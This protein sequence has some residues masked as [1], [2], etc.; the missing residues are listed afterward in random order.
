[1]KQTIT[2]EVPE[3]KVAVIEGNKIIFKDKNDEYPKTWE[4]YLK[5]IGKDNPKT[6]PIKTESLSSFGI[7]K[8]IMTLDLTGKDCVA[9]EAFC[10]LWYLRDY[11]RN[12]SH[13]IGAENTCYIRVTN[14]HEDECTLTREITTGVA[15]DNRSAFLSFPDMKTAIT[16]VDNFKDLII[17][18]LPILI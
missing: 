12:M 15:L 14:T 18:A 11:Y 17:K 3:G 5:L 10:K 9:F 4:R 2:I 7:T 6:L 1:M 13:H 16:F 8:D